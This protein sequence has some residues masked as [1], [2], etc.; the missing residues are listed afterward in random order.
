MAVVTATE[1]R[2]EKRDVYVPAPEQGMAHHSHLSPDHKWVLIAREMDAM[3][4]KPC[5]VLPFDGSSPGRVVGPPGYVCSFAGWS[6][7]GKWMFFS[8]SNGPSG[9][10]VWRQRFPDGDA[11][12]LTFGPTEQEGIAVAPDGRSLLTSVGIDT[13]SVWVHD[14]SGDRQFPFEGPAWLPMEQGSSR[15]IFSPD[16]SKLYFL[17]GH[18]SKDSVGLWVADLTSG[19]TESAL[20]GISVAHSYDVSADGKQIVFDSVDAHGEPRLWVASLDRRSSPRRLESD[21]PETNPVFGPGG[22]LFFWAQE[23]GISYLYHRPLEGGQRKKVTPVPAP[24][25]QTISADGKWVV[26]EAPISGED[27][28]RGVVAYRVADGAAQRVCYSLCVVR[29]TGDGK[30]LY[31]ALLGG[32]AESGNYKTFVVPL[33]HGDSF[34]KLPAGG[35]KSEKDLLSLSGVRG[36]NGLARPGPEVSVYAFNRWTPRRNIYRIPIP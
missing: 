20:P 36:I 33:R 1:S 5:R 27:V 14:K 30:F 35:I 31:V 22:D 26:A 7:D 25:F 17:G 32:D 9:F 4:E 6:P 18:S 21:S 23:G 3:G 2:A 8:A 13:G 28:K 15:A 34:P 11:E 12:Q 10:H 19:R 16:G 24:Q 29:W